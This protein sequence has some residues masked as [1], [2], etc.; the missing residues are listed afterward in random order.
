M[1]PNLTNNFTSF[2]FTQQ[3]Y[4]N[5]LVKPTPLFPTYKQIYLN[6][7]RHFEKRVWK[8]NQKELKHLTDFFFKKNLILWKYVDLER[9]LFSS[10]FIVWWLPTGIQGSCRRWTRC[11][12]NLNCWKIC[13]QPLFQ[14][15]KPLFVSFRISTYFKTNKKKGLLMGHWRISPTL[16]ILNTSII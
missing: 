5:K 9:E 8:K 6:W 7:W 12:Q 14:I 10:F 11:W 15:V 13:A 2:F 4:C 16:I 1:S 3:K